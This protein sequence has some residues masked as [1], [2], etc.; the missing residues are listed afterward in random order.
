MSVEERVGTTVRF[1][2]LETSLLS[3]DNPIEVEV[4]IAASMPSSSKPSSSTRAFHAFKEK[5]K[6]DKDTLFRFRDRFRFLDKTKVRLP[7]LSEK[8]YA[9]AHDEECFYEAAFLSGLSLPI[10]PFIMEFLH[11]LNIASSQLMLTS[12]R[13]VINCMEMWLIVNDGDMIRLDKFVHL[14]HLKESK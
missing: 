9:F 7:L 1:S 12:L 5:W 14:Y 11:H 13:I 10:H 8:V 6:L 4:D 3:S 2:E